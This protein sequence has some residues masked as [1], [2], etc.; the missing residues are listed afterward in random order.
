LEDYDGSDRRV[1][2]RSDTDQ[3]IVVRSETGDLVA[4]LLDISAS[5]ARLRIRDGICPP[6]G[7]DIRIILLDKTE[8]TGRIARVN[9]TSIGVAFDMKLLQPE[10][11]LHHDHLGFDYYRIIQRLQAQRVRPA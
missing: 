3:L 1:D 11:F 8:L 7:D 2:V 4:E 10:D 9:G 6:V 5:G